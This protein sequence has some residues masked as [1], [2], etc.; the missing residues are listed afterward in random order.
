MSI[1]ENEAAAAEVEASIETISPL[2]QDENTPVAE[3][4]EL[5]I[6]PAPVNTYAIE[7]FR[8]VMGDKRGP[9]VSLSLREDL[10]TTM[11]EAILTFHRDPLE[12][13][14]RTALNEI[15][16]AGEKYLDRNADKDRKVGRVLYM[17]SLLTSVKAEL[18]GELSEPV[19][20]A[21]W[22]AAPK[23][24]RSATAAL[25]GAT[26]VNE[27]IGMY[28][29][30]AGQGDELG[31]ATE[32]ADAISEA[33]T[34]MNTSSMGDMF[35][36][37]TASLQNF[38]ADFTLDQLLDLVDQYLGILE[39][40]DQFGIMNLL[41]AKRA[42][43]DASRCAK[44]LK[45]LDKYKATPNA[46]VMEF[47]R[48]GQNKIQRRRYSSLF[49]GTMNFARGVSR[50]VSLLTGA[51]AAVVT[52]A[53]NLSGLV[54]V[55]AH[56][57]A[58]N[59]KGLYK[60][61]LGSRGVARSS[62]AALLV[63]CAA[64]TPEGLALFRDWLAIEIVKG[65]YFI[66]AAKQKVWDELWSAGGDVVQERLRVAI[67]DVG[68]RPD[69][70]AIALRIRADPGVD[71]GLTI[72]NAALLVGFQKLIFGSLNSRPKYSGSTGL[73]ALQDAA[74]ADVLDGLRAF[75]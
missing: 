44:R 25:T 14:R 15:V 8:L 68:A 40:L 49:L 17:N 48:Y 7:D 56:E 63:H 34:T 41:V 64:N 59:V 54:A 60:F 32:S 74:I 16:R 35:S 65:N 19:E 45:V 51:T 39:V 26:R 22:I 52:E 3:A 33:A 1:V 31:D 20:T 50:I 5:E 12:S 75:A 2:W 23:T 18:D 30:I 66:K 11:C 72:A 4:D 73:E 53:I 21:N 47:C 70:K 62:R 58:R 24:G 67:G 61:A 69:L 46:G 55:A 27:S 37:L 6:P 71:S 38:A 43:K 13:A 29:E 28:T 10:K 57:Q 9:L 36:S 42:F